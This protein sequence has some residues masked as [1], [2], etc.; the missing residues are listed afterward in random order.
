MV[1]NF[2]ETNNFINTNQHGFRQG[3]SC[4]TNLLDFYQ[5]VFC[6]WDRSRAVDVVFFDFRKAFDKVPHKRLMRKVRALA[7]QGNFAAWIEICF[8]GRS[9][10]VVVDG[11]PS[12]WTAVSSGVPQGSVLGPLFFVIY[13]NDLE[14]GLSSKVS[15]FAEHTKLGINDANLESVRALQSDLAAIGEWSTVW[16]LPFNLE[17][18]PCPARGHHQSGGELFFAWFGDI[19]C[20]QRN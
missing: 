1:V 19:Q 5:Y 15:I 2:L 11:V 4:V 3:R 17:K 13:I 20:G 9:Q 8:A 7:I 18:M 12:G 6:E 14:L 10:R 16:Q